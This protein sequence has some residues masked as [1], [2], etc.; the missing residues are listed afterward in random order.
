[1]NGGIPVEP[2]TRELWVYSTHGRKELLDK[3]FLRHNAG[4]SPRTGLSSR[5]A[6]WIGEDIQKKAYCDPPT[7]YKRPSR[8]V[9]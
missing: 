1:M 8:P 4:C 6:H 7:P 2:N 3:G 5:S 9:I